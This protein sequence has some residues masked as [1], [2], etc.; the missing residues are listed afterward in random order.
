[1]RPGE[2]PAIAV[3][4]FLRKRGYGGL[5]SDAVGHKLK[6]IDP[7]M[8]T[9]GILEDR[10]SWPPE[11]QYQMIASVDFFSYCPIIGDGRWI[12]LIFGL[13]RLCELKKVAEEMSKYFGVQIELKLFC[14]DSELTSLKCATAA[15]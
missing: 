9:I 10:P 11:M 4:E 2:L 7:G 1:M 8:W 6:R 13:S 14:N 15:L 5:L 3:G 12:F